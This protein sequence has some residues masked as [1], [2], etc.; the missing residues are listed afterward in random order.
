[1]ADGRRQQAIS[2]VVRVRPLR[3]DIGEERSGWEITDNTIS[4]KGNPDVRFTFDTVFRE[5]TSTRE[6]YE[7]VIA[8]P[9]VQSCM[10]G[11][12]ATVFAY[13]QTSSGKSYTMLGEGESPGLVPLAVDDMFAIAGEQQGQGRDFVIMASMIE[14]YNEQ[15]RD[16]L[17]APGTEPRNLRIVQSPLRGVY[18]D[19]A[20]RKTVTSKSQF[21]EY[22]HAEAAARRVCAAHSMNERSSRSHCIVRL[23]VECWDRDETSGEEA[24]DRSMMP[25]E[26][27][28]IKMSA[29]HLV[30]LAGSERLTKTGATHDRKREGS[31]I[32]RS[33]LFLGTL[34]KTLSDPDHKGH[35]SYR[36]SN[37]TRILQT[38]L[39]G[40][41]VTTVIAA[42]T[43]ADIHKEETKSTLLFASHASRVRNVVH[44]NEMS[45]D[46]TRIRRLE[47]E[48]KSLRHSLVGKQFVILSKELCLR[49]LRREGGGSAEV[50]QLRALVSSLQQ[51]NEKLRL[52]SPQPS[53]DSDREVQQLKAQLHEISL[54]RDELERDNQQLL[55]EQDNLEQLCREL[56][57]D[58]DSQVQ[59][60]EKL[61]KEKKELERAVEDARAESAEA[62][63]RLRAAEEERVKAIAGPDD[64]KK[65]LSDLQAK[66]SALLDLYAKAEAS[67]RQA[68]AAQEEAAK[69]WAKEIEKAKEVA[70]AQASFCRRLVHVAACL[71]PDH[72]NDPP[73]DG[74]VKEREVDQ[75]VRQLQSFVSSRQSH[76]PAICPDG[77]GGVSHTDPLA[78]LT[79][80]N[81]PH[82]EDDDEPPPPKVRIKGM[83]P[84][85]PASS[86]S[87]PSPAS[88]EPAPIRI[89]KKSSESRGEGDTVQIK[90]LGGM[91]RSQEEALLR[92]IR[93]LEE[94]VAQRDSTRDVIIDTKLKRMQDLVIRIYNNELNLK[95]VVTRL[96]TECQ[97]LREFVDLRKLSSKLPKNLRGP[98]PNAAELI[99]AAENKPI[100]DHPMWR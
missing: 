17:V 98:P 92:R 4:E 5:R 27:D 84:S 63:A 48:A 36:D 95:E 80:N 68:T 15:L 69:E 58:N 33:L 62:T 88:V 67:H 82:G 46:K 72:Q 55:E 64:L 53:G 18:V 34:I 1:M 26:G 38:A 25:S 39:G 47:A 21:M 79:K 7:S 91:Q 50:M 11:Y 49:K 85:Q 14:I 16:L 35:V 96:A 74:P 90:P 52:E 44:R 59:R 56:E 60:I 81:I 66:H 23:D 77:S 40:N 65:Q 94:A 24:G 31:N 8:G 2:A 86:S 73:G 76:P 37:L 75:A 30:D 22:I 87:A 45:D 83:L 32:N 3:P 12:N 20:V 89:K 51:S 6:L 93:E 41:S 99:S 57:E 61:K 54:Q 42:I 13:G 71:R 10:A 43:Q 29:L 28:S 70:T 78:R 9:I 97:Q 100:R 19:G